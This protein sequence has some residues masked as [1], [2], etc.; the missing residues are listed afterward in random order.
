MTSKKVEDRPLRSK[1]EIEREKALIS[2]YGKLGDPELAAAVRQQRA[3][4]AAVQQQATET[5]RSQQK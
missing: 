5:K 3:G 1:A 4:H 2:R